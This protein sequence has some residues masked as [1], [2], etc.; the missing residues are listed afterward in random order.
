MTMLQRN[1][2]IADDFQDVEN[3]IHE[4]ENQS[5]W[6][7]HPGKP[8]FQSEFEGL[9]QQ[10]RAIEV[11]G[12]SLPVLDLLAGRPASL[13]MNTEDHTSPWSLLAEIDTITGIF[14]SDTS[15]MNARNTLHV[16]LLGKL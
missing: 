4:L 15:L 16:S 7:Q 6:V 1:C 11:F 10:H 12:Q 13:A 8:H 14:K 9:C 3:A 2:F 5:I